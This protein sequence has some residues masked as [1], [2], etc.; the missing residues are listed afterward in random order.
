[1]WR[2]FCRLGHCGKDQM[3]VDGGSTA[4]YV[5]NALNQRVEV[6]TASGSYEYLYDAEGHRISQWLTTNSGAG[7]RIYWGDQVVASRAANGY[8]YFEAK[9]WM[10]T[11]RIRTDASGNAVA[12]Y[13]SLPLEMGIRSA[14]AIPTRSR[15]PPHTRCSTSTMSQAPTTRHSG[16]TPTRRAAG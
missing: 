13:T 6:T 15:T 14:A 2:R 5:Y 9:D 10:G 7:A 3:A 1:M 11:D 4:Q 12:T 8:T 16:C